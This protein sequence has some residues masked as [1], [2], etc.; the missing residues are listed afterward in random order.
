MHY[1]NGK[2]YRS[3]LE[4]RRETAA[5]NQIF[6]CN[7]STVCQFSEYLYSEALPSSRSRLYISLRLNPQ[8][9]LP[10]SCLHR[11]HM[12]TSLQ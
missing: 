10:L 5:F 1:I 4:R 8:S 2:R 11:I 6:L 7:A 3:S 9:T 12:N